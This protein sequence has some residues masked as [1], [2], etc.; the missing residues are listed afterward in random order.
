M[1]TLPKTWITGEEFAE[2][3]LRMRRAGLTQS[4]PQFQ[5]LFARV[6]QR[7]EALFER[8]GHDLM[9][10]YPGCWAAIGMQGEHLVGEDSLDVRLRARERFG[11]GNYYLVQLNETGHPTLRSPRRM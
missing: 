1:E 11:L 9:L 2:E 5:A 8:F 4:H 6:R 7:D 3:S 10:R